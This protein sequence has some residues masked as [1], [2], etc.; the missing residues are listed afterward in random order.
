[1][2]ARRLDYLKE[3][4]TGKWLAATPK[5]MR[6]TVLSAV[7][8][9]D[10]L[11]D[12][13][14]LNILNA[15]SHCDGCNTQFSTTHALGCKVGGI[16][17]SLYD[18]SCD[19]LDWLACAGFQ[20]SNVRDEQHVNPCRDNGGKDESN[21]LA[22]SQIGVQWDINSDQGDFLLRGFWDRNTDCIIVVRICDVNQKLLT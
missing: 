1:M 9:R 14:G 13:Y 5:N 2:G 8:F 12:R 6:G 4:G 7:E 11:R 10:E 15:P 17:H 16:I 3:K 21:K 22:E 19:S 20:L 18:E